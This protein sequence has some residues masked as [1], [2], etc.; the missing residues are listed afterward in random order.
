MIQI[1]G[2]KW[3]RWDSEEEMTA[4]DDVIDYLNVQGIADVTALEL[5]RM[6]DTSK[7][8]RGQ[9]RWAMNSRLTAMASDHKPDYQ[10]RERGYF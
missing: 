6:C 10:R 8:S 2:V 1:G 7:T 4:F 9:F 5:I 3:L